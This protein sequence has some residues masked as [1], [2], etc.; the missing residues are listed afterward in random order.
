MNDINKKQAKKQER[1]KRA[2]IEAMQE[3]F[4]AIVKIAA[5]TTAPLTGS[6]ATGGPYM[7]TS[8]ALDIIVEIAGGKTLDQVTIE[9]GRAALG[10]K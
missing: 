3:R 6:D 2:D 4:D 9:A 1:A 7:A 10:L 5:L 8:A